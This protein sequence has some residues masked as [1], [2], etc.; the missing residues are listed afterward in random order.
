MQA[1][2]ENTNQT[3]EIAVKRAKADGLP[4]VIASNTGATVHT[5]LELGADPKSVV[6]VTHHV[7]FRGPGIDEMPQSDGKYLLDQGVKVLTTTHV[8][9]GVD[10]ACRNK[11]GSIYPA[12][13]WP[14]PCGCWDRESRYVWR[15][16]S[17]P[18][19][20]G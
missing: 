9:A 20:Q 16:P 4:L 19:M 8:L 18:W 12:E 6:C 3:L 11:F 17:W 13:S 10:R 5:A 7:G 1:G 14:A 2:P 15:F